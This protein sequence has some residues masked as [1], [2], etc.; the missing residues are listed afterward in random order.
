[1]YDIHLSKSYPAVWLVIPC[2]I[3]FLHVIRKPP[4][5]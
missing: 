1:L 5:G 3:D 2:L 4:N